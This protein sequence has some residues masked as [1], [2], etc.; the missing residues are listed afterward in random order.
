MAGCHTCVLASGHDVGVPVGLWNGD[1][2]LAVDGQLRSAD[3]EGEHINMPAIIPVYWRWRM[4]IP[5]WKL[6][7]AEGFKEKLRD[8]VAEAGR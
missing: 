2:R 1:R 3:I 5:I 6:V 7:G 8:M 4:E